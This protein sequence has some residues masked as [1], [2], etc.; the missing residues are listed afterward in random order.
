MIVPKLPAL[1]GGKAYSNH[2][3]EHDATTVV[4]SPSNLV[5]AIENASA[6]DVIFIPGDAVFD[7][8]PHY[9]IEVTAS[10][11][12]IASDR[13]VDGSPGALLHS[14]NYNTDH[15]NCLI[16]SDVD[17]TRFSGFRARGPN[18]SYIPEYDQSLEAGCLWAR[19]LDAEIDNCEIYGWPGMGIKLSGKSFPSATGV[20]H[21]NNI[22]HNQLQGLGYGLEIYNGEYEIYYNYFD[23]HR[24]SI[25][26]S[27]RQENGYIAWYNVVGPESRGHAFDMHALE[28]NTSYTGDLAGKYVDIQYNTFMFTEEVDGEDE[29]AV[30]IRGVPEQ[31]SV[32]SNN[33]FKHAGPPPDPHDEG[34]SIHQERISGDSFVNLTIE[35][36]EYGETNDSGDDGNPRAGAPEPMSCPHLVREEYSA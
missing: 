18:Q 1:G 15:P 20:I 32:V 4:S 27:G 10:N 21:H 30:V 26:A 3:T 36:N 35:N 28:E 11:V 2:V 24:H 17:E 12:T 34:G 14:D 6:G 9:N 23:A 19:G 5:S 33:W 13:G 7:M 8:T 31:Q 16:L 22:H 29:N 25:S